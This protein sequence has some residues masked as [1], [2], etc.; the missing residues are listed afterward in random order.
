MDDLENFKTSSSVEEVTTDVVE[1]AGQVE[2]EFK[3]MT[4]LLKFHDKTLTDK[5]LLLMEEGSCFLR[6]NLVIMKIL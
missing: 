5:K 4:E 2:E 1:I 3:D 6:W